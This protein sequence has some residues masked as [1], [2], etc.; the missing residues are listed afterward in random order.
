[1]NKKSKIKTYRS[2]YELWRKIPNIMRITVCLLFIFLFNA[3]AEITYSQSTKISLDM[4]NATIEEVLNAIEKETDFYFLYNSKLINV[5]RT[6]N[7][8][9]ENQTISKVLAVLFSDTDVE[10]RV[11]DKQIILNKS[12][13]G[14]PGTQQSR[15]ITGVVKDN[16]GEA[17]IGANVSV[18]GTT[19]GTIT[20]FDGKF[21]LE[22]PANAILQISYIGYVSEEIPVSNKNSFDI[23]LQEDTQTL[24]EVV[25]VGYGT[26]D[27]K[28]VTSSV[29]SLKN[30][31]FLS[32]AI[33]SPLQ[34]ISGKVAN[35][36]IVNSN[37]A[38][39]NSG[40]SM[41]LRGANSIN[42]GQGP[43]IV[44]D[45]IPGGNI[46]DIQKEDIVSIDVLKDASA[47]AIYGTRGS[48]GVI[49]VT[50]K[51]ASAG[52]PQVTYTSEYTIETIRKKAEVLS[53]DEFVE[54]GLGTDMGART[55][56]FDEVT[57]SNPLT[58]RH[59]ISLSGGT[60][61][62]KAYSSVY[63]KDATGIAI[64]TGRREIGGRV[65]VD[66]SLWDKRVE[67]NGR[68]SYSDIRADRATNS[69]FD[70]DD[71]TMFMIAMKLNPTIPVYD[72]TN[73]TGYN[74]LLGGW[75]EW[76]PVADVKLMTNRTDYKNMMA[77]LTTKVNITE[78]LNT[79]FTM[80][81]K[82]NNERIIRW[83]SAQHKVSRDN[84]VRGYAKMEDKKWNDVSLDWLVNYSKVIDKHSV[85]AVGGYSFQEFNYDGFYAENSDFPVDGV[86]WW[87]M[88]TGT[89]LSEGRAGLGSYKDPR[90]RLI[91]FLG[92]VNYSYDGKYMASVSAR[93][94]G[95]S[96]LAPGNRWGLFPSVSA[97]WRISAEDF[98]KDIEW[99]SDLKIRFGYGKTGNADFKN[100]VG[101]RMYGPDTWWLS[102]GTWFKTYG[103][104]HNVNKNLKW[105]EK[106]EYNAGVDF[107]FLNNRLSGKVDVYKR[108]V[109]G[110][111]YDISVAQPPAVHDKTTMNSG[112]LEN[113]GYEVELTGVVVENKDWNY[114]TTVR[115]SQN[116]TT[117]NSLWGSQTYWD[118][119][120]FEAPGSPGSAV[121]LI[122]GE[123]IG[124][125]Y[126]WKYAGIDDDGNWLLYDKDNNV[127]PASEKSQ[128][129]KRFIG[130]AIPKLILSWEN[131]ISYKDFDL[132]LFFRS[133]IGHDVFNKINMYY[134]LSN[135]TNQNV[136]KSAYEK[137]AH[138]KGEKELCD[139]WLEDGTFLKLD[140]VTL[141]YTFKIPA[142]QKYVRS[143]RATATVRDVFCITGYSGLDPEVN[144]NGLDPG[145]EERYV[146]PKVRS[147]TLGLQFNF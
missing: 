127:I 82:N 88:G 139:Y 131:S 122:A 17:V 128:D 99:L 2:V 100:G 8:E 123:K 111:I 85:K 41:Q 53:A 107:A 20:D 125:Y 69:N 62:F 144:I 71:N 135:V 129:D 93:Y 79:T 95:I 101:T 37:G 91:A 36:S 72:E 76:N 73:P 42:A 84:G 13:A 60:D 38:D 94:E 140:A 109:D 4:H 52:K 12:K 92:R 119:K 136:L 121:R 134:G 35:L 47:A 30:K 105:E 78:D 22:V 57:N 110:L 16:T 117:L 80:G 26:L 64:E 89:Y 81:M 120:D 49:L 96:R 61:N 51:S 147:Y 130:N 141:G 124:R 104:S 70:N 23:L 83:R 1:M 33:S 77:S 137:N 59:V 29:T 90:Q 3:N 5:D 63:Y 145:F 74:V 132:S 115:A 65:N 50:T 143:V 39:P 66:Y 6:V 25:V 113:T 146:Y 112:N 19:I 118:R 106:I 24:N 108:K 133:W 103:L 102:G 44:V 55:D 58:H 54:K 27:K 45:G 34:A 11:E 87:D 14:L 40:V 138:I 46:N 98:M 142:I 97:G 15:N 9:V 7:V 32:G 86:Q 10:Y 68:V 126:I 116:T 114:T 31:D 56:W 48:G 67:F 21:S 75:E 43:L 18:K 28:E